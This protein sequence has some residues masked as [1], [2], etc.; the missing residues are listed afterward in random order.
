MGYLFDGPTTGVAH[1]DYW[2]TNSNGPQILTIN[3]DTP[4]NIALIRVCATTYLNPDRRSNYRV[5]VTSLTG[6]PRVV[7]DG[8]VDTKNDTFGCFHN[9]LVQEEAVIEI[10]FELTREGLYGV[11]LK[12]IEV[13]AAD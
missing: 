7:S 4:S 11:C 2:L 5:T 10:L 6:G 9:H 3:F 13:W 12:K 1:T 8:F